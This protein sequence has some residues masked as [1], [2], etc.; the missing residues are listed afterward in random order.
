M[1]PTIPIA[2][3]RVAVD[4]VATR[5]IQNQPGSPAY[6]CV[7]KWCENWRRAWSS[8]LSEELQG[9]LS[10]LRVDIDHPTDLY[11]FEE[12]SQGANC[13]VIF[14][15]VG[16]LLSGPNA[17]REDPAVGRMLMYQ[18]QPLLNQSNSLGL[19]VLPSQQ[20]VNFSPCPPDGS[21]NEVLQIDMRLHVPLR[22]A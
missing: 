17:W 14:H 13:R 2:Q 5:E 20:M 3:W 21:D 9:Q 12:S 7:C 8:T 22:A 16:K 6:G 19:V 18:Y 11:S 4:L 1:R 10:R 15:L